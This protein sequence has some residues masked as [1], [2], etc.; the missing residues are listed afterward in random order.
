M[1]AA[2]SSFLVAQTTIASEAVV[3]NLRYSWDGAA[4]LAAWPGLA[5]AAALLAVV[6]TVTLVTITR[7]EQA[8]LPLR[9]WA[10]LLT[11]RLIAIVALACMLGGLA[12]RQ[13]VEN[14]RRS[15]VVVLADSSLSMALPAN[16]NDSQSG[17]LTRG[18]E[19]EQLWNSSPLLAQL[20]TQHDIDFFRCGEQLTP[21]SVGAIAD[22]AEETMAQPA[23]GPKFEL[24]PGDAETKLGDALGAV[25]QRY[26]DAPLAGI[27]LC[28]D[29]RNNGGAPPLASAAP[30]REREVE[31][32]T[33]GFGPTDAPPNLTVRDLQAPARAYAGDDITLSAMVLAE[34]AGAARVECRWYRR[35]L[36]GAEGDETLL[37]QETLRFTSEESLLP[38]RINDCPPGPGQYLYRVEVSGLANEQLRSDNVQA[39]KVLVVEQVVRTLLAASGPSRDFHFLRNQLRR[40]KTFAV[41]VLLQSATEIST[42][43]DSKELTEFPADEEALDRY[44]AIVAFDLDWAQLP[45]PTQAALIRWVADEA[46]GLIMAPGPVQMPRILQKRSFGELARLS[47]VDFAD[48]LL[49]VAGPPRNRP[50]PRPV[51]L[52]RAG[53]S[54]EFLWLAGSAAESRTAW[55]NFVGLYGAFPATTPKPGA[56]VYATLAPAAD[57][58][59]ARAEVLFA[60]QFYGGGRTFFIGS[61]ECWRLRGASP[62]LFTGLFTKLLR[63]VSQGRLS[64]GAGGAQLVFERDRYEVGET[65]T[66]R[67]TLRRRAG[68]SIPAALVAQLG[69]GEG[70]AT[71]ME[72]KPNATQRG[73]YEAKFPA[74]TVGPLLAELALGTGEPLSAESQVVF[75][76][77]ESRDTLRDAK[78]LAALADAAGGHYYATPALAVS[79]GPKLPALAEAIPSREERRLTFGNP[80]AQFAR[81]WSLG[82]LLAAG[83]A[84]ITS[85]LLR[86]LWSLA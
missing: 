65:I 52:T 33:I 55:E 9:R 84:L 3:D 77:L 46:G 22:D 59:D 57:S 1:I 63:H 10:P 79:G 83:C 15:R 82:T 43:E 4:E 30:A 80:D 58:T 86:R 18:Q 19:L 60:E 2:P 26:A 50:K 32:H 45:P 61:S 14:I 67:A 37:G 53:E 38:V 85:W 16:H 17:Q 48:N 27:I 73:A 6:L 24:T 20:Q 34:S 41:D 5:I 21:L 31:I 68:E 76:V 66:L 64:R 29:G 12:R 72:L 56:T 23:S 44:D 35:P 74:A 42:A 47:P 25:L 11:L 69:T 78:L 81:N 70:Q 39:A 13:G 49:L 36:A 28:S 40:D 7:R 54:A 75:P 71:P 51:Q 62:D 8:A